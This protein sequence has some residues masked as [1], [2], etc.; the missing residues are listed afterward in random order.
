MSDEIR[1]DLKTY[2]PIS[3]IAREIA[4]DWKVPHINLAAQAYLRAMFSLLTIKDAY[5][6]DQ[7]DDIVLRFLANA[8]GWRGPVAKRVKA[9]LRQMLKDFNS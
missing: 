1:T 2:R 6:A 3:A 7:A 9:E 8:Q 4:S 5:G